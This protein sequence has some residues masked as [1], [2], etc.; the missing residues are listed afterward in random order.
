MAIDLLEKI[1]IADKR[2]LEIYH[3]NFSKFNA[4]GSKQDLIDA[5]EKR[6][7]ILDPKRASASVKKIV[8]DLWE[9]IKPNHDWSNNEHKNG[10]KF[11]GAVMSG[12]CQYEEYISYCTPDKE[13][14]LWLCVYINKGADT[15]RIGIIHRI[16]NVK[17]FEWNGSSRIYD[18]VV[19]ADSLVASRILFE[20][21]L[22]EI[23]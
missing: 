6:L 1:K 23:I 22:T 8:R 9:S 2:N 10:V 21:K 17:G 12:E 15:A 13:N 20:N 19:C 18:E 7:V 14:R 4:D 16:G 3:V 5:I 11:G